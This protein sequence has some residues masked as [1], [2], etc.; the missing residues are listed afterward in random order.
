MTGNIALVK[1]LFR[2]FNAQRWNDKIKPVE[3]VEMD[4]HAHKMVIAWCLGKYEESAGNFVNWNNIIKGGIFELLRRIVISDIKSP[5]YNKIRDYHKD[6]FRKLSDWV[7]EQLESKIEDEQIKA[8]LHQYL[9]N[10]NYFDEQSIRILEA[11]HKYASYWEFLI[12]KNANPEGYQIKE[13]ERELLTSINNYTE[14]VGIKKLLTKQK[15][16]DFIDLTG[17]LRFQVRWSQIPRMPRTSV[18]GHSMFVA[19]MSYLFARDNDS[20]PKR[21]YNNFFGGLY[22]DLPEAVTRDIISPVKQSSKEFHDLIRHIEHELAENEI[23]PIIENEW[24]EEI[25]YFTEDEFE[26]KLFLDNKLVKGVEV[27]KINELY[28]SDEY[29]PLDGELIRAADQL[30]AFMEAWSSNQIGVKSEEFLY[31][32]QEIK[33]NY[34]MKTL[35]KVPIKNLYSG[36]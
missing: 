21:L 25:Q 30:A 35:G 5:I 32:M 23:Y 33:K 16:S 36:F 4:K 2:G 31:A 18:L 24:I 11:A 34:A 26:N 1:E 10:D 6:T 7:F 17:Q 15:V 13:I 12:I 28:N 14:L 20:C 3:L 19:S 29:S 8:E 22:H 9:L 27:S